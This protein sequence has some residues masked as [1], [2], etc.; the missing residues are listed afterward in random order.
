MNSVVFARSFVSVLV[1]P[2]AC[3]YSLGTHLQ[4]PTLRFCLI[5]A[6]SM[7]VRFSSKDG[8]SWPI[9]SYKLFQSV[10]A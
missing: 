10:T 2:S 7:M 4:W 1:N 9:A 3:M 5:D 6:T 8:V